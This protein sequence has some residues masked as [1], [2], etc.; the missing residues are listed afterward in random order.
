M[1]QIRDLRINKNLSQQQLAELLSIDRTTVAKWESGATRPK[2]S[3]LPRLAYVF[4]C[5]YE[6]LIAI[7]NSTSAKKQ[8]M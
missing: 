3:M 1:E 2:L 7:I 6:K 4:E 5:T 8:V